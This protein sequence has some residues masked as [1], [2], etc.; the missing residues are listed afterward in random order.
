MGGGLAAR[1]KGRSVRF[2]SPPV[3]DRLCKWSCCVWWGVFKGATT[4]LVA[5]VV[6]RVLGIFQSFFYSDIIQENCIKRPKA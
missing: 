5:F 1:A 3:V 2:M 4:S 6:I